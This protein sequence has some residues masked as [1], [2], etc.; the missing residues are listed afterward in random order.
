MT[1]KVMEK[2]LIYAKQNRFDFNKW[3]KEHMPFEN[4]PRKMATANGY[5]ILLLKNP[6]FIF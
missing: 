1:E 6:E 3:A 2:I 5:L 4:N